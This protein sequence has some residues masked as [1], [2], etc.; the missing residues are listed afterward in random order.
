MFFTSNIPIWLLKNY[1]HIAVKITHLF[2]H[3]VQLF[4]G[5]FNALIIVVLNCLRV[6]PSGPSFDLV[7]LSVLPVDNGFG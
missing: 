6:S 7:V 3:V 1:F 5:F 2:V 4:V